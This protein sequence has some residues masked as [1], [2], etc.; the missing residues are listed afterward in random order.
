MVSCDYSYLII[1]IGLHSHSIKYYI[2]H[3]YMN[4]VN[5]VF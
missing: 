4:A 2:I 3:D 1:M 5:D